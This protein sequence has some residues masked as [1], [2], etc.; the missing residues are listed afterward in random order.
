[1]FGLG[2]SL[3]GGGALS[4]VFEPDP[5]SDDSLYITIWLAELVLALGLGAAAMRLADA[6]R[7]A[8]FT[9]VGAI[10]GTGFPFASALDTVL[11]W[12]LNGGCGLFALWVLAGSRDDDPRVRL[13][14]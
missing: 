7:W 11:G 5:H 4:N 13:K 10:A 12:V 1:M 14:A 2:V 3:L 8:Y 9:V 6:R